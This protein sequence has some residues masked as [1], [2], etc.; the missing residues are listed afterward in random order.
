LTPGIA[1]G[2]FNLVTGAEEPNAGRE[3]AVGAMIFAED[4][5]SSEEARAIY[6]QAESFIDTANV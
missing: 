5:G 2:G 4:W 3:V 6:D 1:Y